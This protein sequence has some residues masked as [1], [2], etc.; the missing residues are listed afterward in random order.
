MMRGQLY[1]QWYLIANWSTAFMADDNERSHDF[2]SMAQPRKERILWLGLR[3]ASVR[4][5][6]MVVKLL[7][8]FLG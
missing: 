4:L 3:I 8:I 6:T 1:T 5:T 2:P 7:L